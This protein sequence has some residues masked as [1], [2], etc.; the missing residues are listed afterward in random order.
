MSK[1]LILEKLAL[2]YNRIL[3]MTK[4]IHNLQWLTANALFPS[5]ILML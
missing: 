5:K 1:I 2:I 3:Q 4:L